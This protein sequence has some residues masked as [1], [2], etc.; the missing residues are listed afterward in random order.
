ME[1][2]LKPGL[3]AA[4]LSTEGRLAGMSFF[5][6]AQSL[7]NAEVNEIQVEGKT[8][9]AVIVIG[10]EIHACILPWAKGRWFGRKAVR[11]L[12]RVIEEHGEAT[13]HATTEEGRRF[14][15]ALGFEEHNGIYRSTKKWVLNQSSAL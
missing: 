2:I 6:F 12:N 11:I 1:G 3:H 4:W 10:S 9:G 8:C 7:A 14:V 13:T 5:H 15:Q